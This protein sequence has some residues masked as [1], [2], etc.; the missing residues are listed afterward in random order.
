MHIREDGH[1]LRI[2][3]GE[4]DRHGRPRVF[5]HASTATHMSPKEHLAQVLQGRHPSLLLRSIS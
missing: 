3:V 5:G 2:F 4:S 1:L